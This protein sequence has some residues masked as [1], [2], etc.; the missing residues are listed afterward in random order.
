MYA[1]SVGRDL[2]HSKISELVRVLWICSLQRS[3]GKALGQESGR[4]FLPSA[5]RGILGVESY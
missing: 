3:E 2:D 1:D 4:S 5:A